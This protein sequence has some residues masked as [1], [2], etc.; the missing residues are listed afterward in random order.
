ML[1]GTIWLELCP[2][3]VPIWIDLMLTR[4]F[5]IRMARPDPV[6]YEMKD[7]GGSFMMLFVST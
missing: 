6:S 5:W 2:I 7:E 3:P 4:D 1:G